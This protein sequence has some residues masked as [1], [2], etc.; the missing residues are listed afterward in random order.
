MDSRYFGH[1]ALEPEVFWDEW[2][3][4]VEHGSRDYW[5]GCLG[6]RSSAS[7]PFLWDLSKR[8]LPVLP[9]WF[10][11]SVAH[12]SNR[13]KFPSIVLQDASIYRLNFLMSRSTT[14]PLDRRVVARRNQILS[15]LAE[16]E[17]PYVVF[18]VREFNPHD[19][20]N[21]LRNRRIADFA[22]GMKELVRL[23]FN[24]VRLM[25]E[26]Q[27]PL[28]T[29]DRHHLDWQV[30]RDGKPGDELAIISG[31]AFVVSTTTGG[32]CLALGY[33]RP[34]LYIDCSRFFLVFLG[35]ELATFSVPLMYDS[36]TRERLG[37]DALLERDLG[38]IGDQ[39]LF[40]KAGMLVTQ[41]DPERLKSQIVEFAEILSAE[42]NASQESAQWKW[43]ELLSGKLGSEIESR[44][45]RIMARMLASSMKEFVC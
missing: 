36:Q 20:Q 30:Q 42:W 3:S 5:F 9:S 1:Q 6:P 26:T 19:D 34:V 7:N 16:S 13:Y 27:D 4:A 12:W 32:D 37:L 2:Q 23:G 45:G 29:P 24:V 40:S 25:S 38:W 39:R 41:S 14:L 8:T 21:D 28:I 44:H 15:R 10:V 17:R 33:R 22:L 18:T 35:T 43:R 11:T 31:A